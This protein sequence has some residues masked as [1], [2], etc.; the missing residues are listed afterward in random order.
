MLVNGATNNL[1]PPNPVNQSERSTRK[2]HMTQLADWFAFPG[3][4]SRCFEMI[5]SSQCVLRSFVVSAS[6][7]ARKHTTI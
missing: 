5:K 6:R 2:V 7:V 4:V 1:L 3:C